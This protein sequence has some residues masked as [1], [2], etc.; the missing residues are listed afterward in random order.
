MLDATDSTTLLSIR[1]GQKRGRKKTGGADLGVAALAQALLAP[2]VRA[3]VQ[4]RRGDGAKDSPR[5][6]Q[7]DVPG[8]LCVHKGGLVSPST[9]ESQQILAGISHAN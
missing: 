2:L 1:R 7:V 9:N 6:A 8:A 3:E 5:D 4:E